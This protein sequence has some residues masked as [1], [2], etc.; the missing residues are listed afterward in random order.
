MSSN[1]IYFSIKNT[2][3]VFLEFNNPSKYLGPL[4]T[5][6]EKKEAGHYSTTGKFLSQ[7]GGWEIKITVQ[8]IGE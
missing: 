1:F 2:R 4:V 6:M 8:R 3:N 5:T 7:K